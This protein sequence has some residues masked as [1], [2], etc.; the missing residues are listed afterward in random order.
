MSHYRV[1]SKIFLLLFIMAVSF[2]LIF[3][4]PKGL[5]G[6]VRKVVFSIAYPFQKVLYFVS[7]KGSNTVD[8]IASISDL[9]KENTRL[10]HENNQLAAEVAALSDQK[11]ENES[12]RA[13]L[14]LA[15]RE[16]FV[17]TS[18]FVIGQDPQ[19]L[20][21]WILIDKGADKGIS[22]GMPVI[23]ADSILVGKVEE[24]FPDSAKVNLLSN[25]TSVINATDLDTSARG[26]VKGEFGLGILLDMVA[27]TDVINAGDTVV[28]SG[29]GG[30]LP[31]GL[32]VGRIQD[33]KA[34]DDRLFQ[35]ALVIPRVK[36][37]KLD[38]V[39][40]ITN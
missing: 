22:A 10:L 26:V 4:N 2:L 16:S 38:M 33:V 37:Q 19:G 32:L 31:K 13:Q 21:T 15:P 3:F 23:V 39:F 11:K 7:K 6:P 20:G 9:K 24:V 12:L 8:F 18:A 1:A 34:T 14:D 27:Q 28:T 5:F 30:N 25:P 29:L 40:V 35:Q 36:Y 17:L